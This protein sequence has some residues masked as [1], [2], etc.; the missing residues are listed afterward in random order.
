MENNKFRRYSGCI[1]EEYLDIIKKEAKHDYMGVSSLIN[2]LIRDFCRQLETKR[3][4]G[5]K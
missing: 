3:V 5:E 4:S 1:E 2:H